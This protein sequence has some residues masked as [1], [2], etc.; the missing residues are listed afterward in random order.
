MLRVVKHCSEVYEPGWGQPVR[1][2]RDDMGGG[3]VEGRDVLLGGGGLGAT[4]VWRC[5]CFKRITVSM[6]QWIKFLFNPLTKPGR[7]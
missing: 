3:G 2:G 6:S 5:S 1:D 4:G 7:N